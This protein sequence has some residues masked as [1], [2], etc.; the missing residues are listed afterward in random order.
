MKKLQ[1]PLKVDGTYKHNIENLVHKVCTLARET[2][3]EHEKS[4]L[5]ASSVVYGGVF[6][7]FFV[8]F[9][10]LEADDLVKQLS[11]PFTPEDAFMFGPHSVLDLDHI[12]TTANFIDTLPFDGDFPAHFMAEDDVTSESSVADLSQFIPK[13]PAVP[14]MCHIISVGKLVE[15][16]LEVADQVVVTSVLTAGYH[17]LVLLGRVF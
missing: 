7:H 14:S 6:T 13:M 1:T 17:Q 11:E 16:A 12:Q 9:D 15:S 2:T 8:D 4:C 5:R 10:E 3:E